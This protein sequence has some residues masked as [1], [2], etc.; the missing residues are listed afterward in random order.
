MKTSI[1]RKA[2][3]PSTQTPHNSLRLVDPLTRLDE[4]DELTRRATRGDR[5]A[6]GAIAAALGP[7]LLKE[8]RRHMK[9]FE[10]EAEDV[11]Q[12]FW[13]HLLEGR[14]PFEPAHGR[15]LEW[16]CRILEIF[17]HV[18][19]CARARDWGIDEIQ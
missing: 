5:R 3:S 18:S 2:T 17:A 4:L 9:G 6:I 7:H 8:A 19:H 15:A 16:M 11:L 1:A 10:E 14:I 13:V 12:D